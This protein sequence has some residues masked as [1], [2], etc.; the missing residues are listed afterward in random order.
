MLR[1]SLGQ[2]KKNQDGQRTEPQFYTL[3][4]LSE[5][6]RVSKRSIE[7]WV[8]QHRLPVVKCGRLNRFPRIEIQKRL[9]NGK[10]F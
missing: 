3:K 4:E 8:F 7:K 2:E 5:L 6:L 1:E 10:L 9:L